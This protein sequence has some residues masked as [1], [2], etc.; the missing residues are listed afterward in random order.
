MSKSLKPAVHHLLV[1][2]VSLTHTTASGIQMVAPKLDPQKLTERQ[3]TLTG[4]VI[5]TSIGKR[6]EDGERAEKPCEEGD[7][8]AFSSFAG[9]RV[10]LDTTTF[11]ILSFD[12]VLGVVFEESAVSAKPSKK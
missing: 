8:I 4:R 12:E 5:R 2:E 7:T 3:R 1:Q 6:L 10:D 11:I 9:H